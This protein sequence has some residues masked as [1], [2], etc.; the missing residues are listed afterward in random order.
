MSYEVLQAE[1]FWDCIDSLRRDDRYK[2]ALV[3]ALS[4]LRSKPFRNPKLKTHDV[5]VARNG[6]KLFASDVGGRRSDRRI[7]WQLFNRT[8]VLLL[9][10]PHKV[11]DRAKRMSI[12][13]DPDAQHYA[14]YERAPDSDVTQLYVT[15]RSRIGKLFMAWTDAEL[16]SFG[17][18]PA[19]VANLRR[20]DSDDDLLAME[21]ELGARYFEAAFSLVAYGHPDGEEAAAAM[22]VEAGEDDPAI[23]TVTEEDREV[24]RRLADERAGA[25][26]TRVEPEFLAEVMGRP[27]EDWMIFLHPDQRAAIGRRFNG[28][29][30]VRGSA[31]TG[32][33]VVGLHRAVWLAR[34]NLRLREER[35]SRLIPVSDSDV[36]PILFTTFIKTLPPVFESLYMRLPGAIAGEVE[37]A[38]VDRLAMKVCREAGERPWLDRRKVDDAFSAAFERI[39][40]T[41]TPLARSGFTNNYLRDEVTVV[42]KGRAIDSVDT[43]LGIART[44]RQAPMGSSLRRQTWDLREAWDQEMAERGVVDFPDIILRALHYAR[45]LGQP[46]YSSVI[47]DEAQDITMAGLLFLRAL[48]NAPHPD[49]DRPDG[50]LILGDGAQ[51]IYPGG[52]TLRQAGIEVRGRTTVLSTNYRNT[53]EIIAAA[54][55]VAGDSPVQDLAE[56]F[57]RGEAPADA[58]REGPRPLLVGTSGWESQFDEIVRRIDQITKEDRNIGPGDIA[59]LVPINHQVKKVRDRI[60]RTRFGVQLLDK[61]DGR[62]NNLIKVG[63]FHRGKG[64][65]FKAVFLPGLS[66]GQ[67]PRRPKKHQTVEEAAEARDLEISQL[68]VAMTRARDVLVLLYSGQPSDALVYVTDRFDRQEPMSPAQQQLW[69]PSTSGPA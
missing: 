11:Y 20:V 23:P 46:R 5:G 30:R 32:K 60:K 2:A 63:T 47:V 6:K 48:V 53:G 57:R 36:R 3:D 4:E 68:F 13:F 62:P 40:T 61:Y 52:Y 50:M 41:D 58:S 51:R 24:E 43:Y 17:F 12:D 45:R 10:G 8:I 42:I 26:F 59:V 28:P 22:S 64:L 69:Q 15:Q 39:V 35:Q 44:G 29:A 49:R 66:K 14:V 19:I 67:F 37:F 1:S 31:G 16:V 25:W 55:A 38:N 9:Y 56:K 34:R 27:I 18:H 65:E 7:V 33:T 21:G 54:M